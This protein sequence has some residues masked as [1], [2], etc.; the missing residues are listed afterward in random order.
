MTNFDDF[1]EKVRDANPIE[2][3]MQA[4]EFGGITLKGNGRLRT[5]TAHDSLKVR[6]DMGR[7]FWYS[8]NISG[9]V[10]EWVA[11]HT[12]KEFSEVLK[13]LA[14]RA[15]I[16]MPK[17]QQVNEG[18]VKRVRATADVFSVAAQ[19]FHRWLMG[20]EERGVKADADAL[21]YVHEQRGW[22]DET[23]RA[24][25]VGFSGRKTA[26]QLND[27]KKEMQMFGIDLQSPA[28]VAIFGLDK[29][30]ETWAAAH[31]L[32][33]E[34]R[35]AGWLEKYRIH[36]LMD[37]PGIIYAHP[38]KGGVSY[39][40]RRQ[41]PGFDIIKDK[42]GERVWKSFNPHKELV[43]PKQAYVNHLHRVDEPLICCEGQ[44]DAITWGQLGKSALAFC[45]L[46]GEIGYMAT[47]D[48]ERLRK[49]AAWINKHPAV[50]LFLDDDEAGQKA[51]KQAAHLI[52]MKIQVGRMTRLVAR[53]EANHVEA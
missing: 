47:E 31:D 25:L 26:A 48:A 10:F 36:G 42:N 21:T 28:A 52:G 1:V 53:D 16:E 49:L 3:V 35:D 19:V 50:Y 38:W 41:L 5:A 22:T 43:G 51:V 20:D 24:A 33:D 7:F 30:I 15:R 14:E 45:G 6:T 29:D 4:K 12:G 9:D 32:L 46:M 44:G 8:Q 11:K 34:A 37:K 40:T 18:E 39:L 17:F 27:M 23:L 13:M 2:D